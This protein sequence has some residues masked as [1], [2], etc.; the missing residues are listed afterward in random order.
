ML[1]LC[2]ISSL[3]TFVLFPGWKKNCCSTDYILSMGMLD[4]DS[5]FSV[6][7]FTQSLFQPSL[8]VTKRWKV[9]R[10]PRTFVFFPSKNTE[11]NRNYHLFLLFEN[12]GN[13]Y[14]SN[15][16]NFLHFAFV[17]VQEQEAKRHVGLPSCVRVLA[18]GQ[19]KTCADCWNTNKACTFSEYGDATQL[20]HL[21]S[22]LFLL[23][24]GLENCASLFS[25]DESRICQHMVLQHF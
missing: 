17:R 7:C 3:E 6:C 15:D 12:C 21:S 18:L 13:F 1:H 23:C 10:K 24:F 11:R 25:W 2:Y 16:Q 8:K 9:A 4:F 19:Y 5:F 14:T 20:Y 22:K